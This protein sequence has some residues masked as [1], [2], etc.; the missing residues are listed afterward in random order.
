LRDDNFEQAVGTS[1]RA[2]PPR[3]V[4][5]MRSSTAGRSPSSLPSWRRAHRVRAACAAP[6]NVSPPRRRRFIKVRRQPGR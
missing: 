6:P 5:T 4:C 3:I 2:L 1:R